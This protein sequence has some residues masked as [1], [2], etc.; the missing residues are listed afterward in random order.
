M[1]VHLDTNAYSDW[2]RFGHWHDRLARA[3]RIVVWIAAVVREV[4]GL[5]LTRDRH[6]E[7]LPQVR[8]AEME[9]G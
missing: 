7:N 1:I 2:H 8:V 9:E 3:D 5:L 6:F 4:G